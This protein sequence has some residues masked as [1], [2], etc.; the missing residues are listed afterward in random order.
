MSFV[1]RAVAIR[2]YVGIPMFM[3]REREKKKWNYCY[4]NLR[5]VGIFLSSK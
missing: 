3:E 4:V 5:T 2:Y 1:K